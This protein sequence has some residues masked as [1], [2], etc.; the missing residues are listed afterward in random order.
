MFYR[1]CFNGT[2]IRSD[3]KYIMFTFVIFAESQSFSASICLPY[4]KRFSDIWAG[5]YVSFAKSSIGDIY[6]W[7]LNNYY[8]LGTHDMENRFMPV[9]IDTLP[10]DKKWQCIAGGQHH[11]VAV[12][13]NG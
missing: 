7:G 8:Q 9:H 3:H 11:T 12:N 5:T 13:N 10:A 2:I 6:A 4:I 1:T